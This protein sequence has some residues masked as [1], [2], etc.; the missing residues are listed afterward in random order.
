MSFKKIFVVCLSL[1]FFLGFKNL[2][3][4]YE[5]L[6]KSQI[7]ELIPSSTR[8]V[9]SLLNGWTITIGGEKKE[10][11]SIPFY[12]SNAKEITF[13]KKLNVNSRDLK[14]YSWSLYFLGIDDQIEVYINEQYIGKYFGGMTPF[15][16]G[17]PEKSL[18]RAGNSLKFVITPAEHGARQAKEQNLFAKK[19]YQGVVREIFLIG[20]P[21][22]WIE[23]L[24]YK[25]SWNSNYSKWRVNV[26]SVVTAGQI[27]TLKNQMRN[28]SIFS[29]GQNEAKVTA[30]PIIYDR[31]GREIAR[32]SAKQIAITNERT[33][34]TKFS[35]RVLNPIKWSPN[36]PVLYRLT[37]KISKRGKVIDNL[38]SDLAF[39]AVNFAKKNNQSFLLLN[40]KPLKVKGVDYIE[41]YYHTGASLDAS[42]LK[43]D[44]A[45]MKTTGVNLVR[46]KYQ[47]PHPY[48]IK[49][50]NKYGLLVLVDLPVY[51]VPNPLLGSAEIQARMQNIA[52]RTYRIYDANPSVAA[53][54]ISE[55]AVENSE[56]VLDFQNKILK[57]FKPKSDK[58][59][60]K[61]I[62]YRSENPVFDKYDFVILRA[63][64]G[65]KEVWQIQQNVK[66]IK[67][68]SPIPLILNF[69]LIIQPNNHNGYSDP[70]SVESQAFYLYRLYKVSQNQNL[71]GSLIW[72]YN[73][74]ELNNPLLIL[75]NIN[76]NVC[77][78]GL[79]SVYRTRRQAFSTVQALFNNEKEPLFY[80]GSHRESGPTIF[81]IIGLAG[82][83]IAVLMLNRFKRFREYIFRALMRPYNFYADIRDQRIISSLQT[84]ILGILISVSLGLF[85]ASVFFYYR[86]NE[87]AEYIFMFVFPLGN[88]QETF[89]DL[90]WTPGLMILTLGVLFFLL[91]FIIAFVIKLLSY[92]VKG[93]IFFNDTFI[94]TIWAATPIL[95]LMPISMVLNRI[96]SFYPDFMIWTM[97]LALLLFIWTGLRILRSTAV[98]FDVRTSKSY[99]IGLTIF[100]ALVA[101]VLSIYQLKF[102]II[103]YGQYL[104]EA[105][106]KI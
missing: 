29:R 68:E 54:G 20:A 98:V 26:S 28:D 84:Y 7:Y 104:F 77:F 25:L 4:D 85:F 76:K 44:A 101:I 79:M 50:C 87:I 88:L 97:V 55:G 66:R 23:D 81:L 78:S 93:R 49:V 67:Q 46:C 73:D 30:Q 31:F 64:G 59:I 41:D 14:N 18:R 6:D 60:Y 39:R 34:K 27:E 52:E 1:T 51:D 86:S 96:T 71:A 8:Y 45:N 69:G 99:L 37:F 90:I 42:R 75:N 95:F 53:W 43:K 57:I 3:A 5:P 102:S 91:I 19:I 32:G 70:M 63:I 2:K 65:K 12:V 47:T 72:S 40:G 36:N 17:I 61:T 15:Q 106:L 9:K 24:K 38:S 48:F 83:I 89:Y 22:I 100:A 103:S 62:S 74:Y 13:E 94:I 80:A 21:Q 58:L 11:Q 82:V 56:E 33:V 105:M 16:V 92:L 35:I 10:S